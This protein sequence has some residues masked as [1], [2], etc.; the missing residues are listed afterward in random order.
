MSPVFFRTC[1]GSMLKI[2]V[3]GQSIGRFENRF[4]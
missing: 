4:P 3:I 2:F 1:A